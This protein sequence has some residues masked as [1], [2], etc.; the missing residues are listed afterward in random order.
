MPRTYISLPIHPF[1]YSTS[2]FHYIYTYMH[3]TQM[4]HSDTFSEA[5]D[6]ETNSNHMNK[7]H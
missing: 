3:S 5:K 7:L 2:N 1:P 4:K 6:R